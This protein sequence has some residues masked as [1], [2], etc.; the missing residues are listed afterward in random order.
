MM[1]KLNNAKVKKIFA[2]V[3]AAVLVICMLLPMISYAL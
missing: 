1:K 3:L 2:G